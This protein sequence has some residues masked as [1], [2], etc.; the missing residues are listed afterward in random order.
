MAEDKYEQDGVNVSEGDK[1][2]RFAGELCRQTYGNSPYVEVR[3]FSR[4]HFRGPRGF[5]LKNLPE[6]C[7]LEAAPDGDGTKPGLVVGAE[8]F[9]NAAHGWFAMTGG[10]VTRWGGYPLIF[11]NNLDTSTIGKEGDP[12]NQAFRRMMLCLKR[13]C[14]EHSVVMFKGETAELGECVGSKNPGATVKYL[15]SGVAIGAYNPKT[16]ITGDQVAEGMSV[17]ALREYGFRN[18]GVSSVYKALAMAY[19]P[20]WFSNPAA[21]DA[22]RKAAV[23]AVL[24]DEFLVAANGWHSENFEP[25][26]PTYL[27]VH[28]TGG[29]IK[30]KFA[31]D[32][33]F[34]RGLSAR[35]DG[36]WE[37]PEIMR[38]CA[39][40]RG[41]NDDECYKAWHGGQGVLA[42]INAD[43][44][45][46][47]TE[48]ARSFGIEAKKAGTITKEVSPVVTIESK[49]SGDVITFRA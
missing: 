15:W 31:E 20:T 37:P 9:D 42:V 7:W 40:W 33:L 16:I 17:M 2:S 29:A 24:Y 46:R 49:F 12:V 28:L 27:N 11:V 13:I 30:S 34:P 48:M 38:Q 23:P 3:D 36:L 22:I 21:Q 4:G 6:G 45:I 25:I 43:D 44:E 5:R 10:D 1:F 32:I 14:D 18:N 39:E 47:F 35:L 26:I 19:G 41:M 8:D